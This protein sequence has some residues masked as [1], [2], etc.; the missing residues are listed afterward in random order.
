MTSS[1]V[2]WLGLQANGDGWQAFRCV[3]RPEPV[4]HGDRYVSIM[5]PMTRRAAV[6]G[7]ANP[8]KWNT[9]N[10]CETRGSMAA[11]DGPYVKTNGHWRE[12]DYRVPDWD[13]GG[14]PRACFEYLG[15]TYWLDDFLC[16]PADRWNMAES[17]PL[18]DWHGYSPQSAWDAIVVRHNPDPI[19]EGE[20]IQVGRYIHN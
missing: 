8:G 18:R 16:I 5:G 14:E 7:E 2:W 13:E 15:Y 12:V 19:L 20:S 1:R 9:V 10:E 6:W 3:Y 11:H 17:D 4:T